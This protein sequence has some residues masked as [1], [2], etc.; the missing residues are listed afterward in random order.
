VAFQELP[1]EARLTLN[2]PGIMLGFGAI[3]TD[4][5]K[6]GMHRLRQCLEG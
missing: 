6:E 1:P 2:R 5:I 3:T 4:R